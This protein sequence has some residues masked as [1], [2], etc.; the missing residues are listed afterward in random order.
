MHV[1]RVAAQQR[2]HAVRAQPRRVGLALVAQGVEARGHHERGRDPGQVLGAQ[3]GD[4]RVGAVGARAQERVLVEVD[5]LLRQEEALRER[6]PRRGLGRDVR[7]GV[8]EELEGRGRAAVGG[9]AVGRHRGQVAAGA[10]AADRDAGRVG[11]ELGRAGVG[12][13]EGGE[14]VVDRGREAVLGGEAV[15]HGEHARAR[16]RGQQARG[17]VVRVEVAHDPPAAVEEDQQADGAGPSASSGT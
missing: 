12:V 15:V 4:A 3:G 2:R 5:A 14:R 17:R 10:V 13:A 6:A 11:A 1:A 7:D 8:D 9:G 16:R